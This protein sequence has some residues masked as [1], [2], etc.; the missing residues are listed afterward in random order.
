MFLEIPCWRCDLDPLECFG[1]INDSQWYLI[2]TIDL[3]IGELHDLR[4]D[5]EWVLFVFS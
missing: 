5:P 1:G 2:D 3:V 4:L